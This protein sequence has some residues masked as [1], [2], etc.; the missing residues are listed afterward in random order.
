MKIL[1]TG[2]NGLLGHHVVMEL[3]N[4]AHEVRIIV[5]ST[6]KIGFDLSQVEVLTGS[7]VD[8]NTIYESAKGCDGIIHIAAATDTN[9]LNYRE[10]QLINVDATKQ[11]IETAREL[12]IRKLVFISTANT[13]GYGSK[14]NLRMRIIQ[15]NIHLHNPIMPR[16]NSKQNSFFQLTPKR[17]MS[18]L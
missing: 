3:L 17:I 18:L 6:E 8:K 14:K 12:S 13:I 4:R 1:I 5:R 11:L 16:A 2:A 9:L 7:F 15:L 10:Y